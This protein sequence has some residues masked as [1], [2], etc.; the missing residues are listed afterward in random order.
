MH[1]LNPLA[2]EHDQCELG[3]A[4]QIGRNH[5]D[6]EMH[7][8]TDTIDELGATTVDRVDEVDEAVD[9]G[10]HAVKATNVG[11]MSEKSG[12]ARPR[13][14][15]IGALV[16]VDVED[17]VGVRLARSLERNVDEALAEDIREDRG[18]QGTVLV[19]D[20]VRDVPRPDFAR[21]ATRDVRDV[22]LD[23]RGEG[24]LVV[25]RRDPAGELRMPDCIG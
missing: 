10:V 19:E 11:Y 25:D 17:R 6:R 18:A 2:V 3:H 7:L 1:R 4:H 12:S 16:V 9:L 5:T 8:G 23:D 15:R 24:R 13:P 20:L 14:V 22:V 21:V